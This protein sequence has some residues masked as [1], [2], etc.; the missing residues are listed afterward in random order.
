MG[1]AMTAARLIHLTVHGTGVSSGCANKQA[2]TDL[3]THLLVRLLRL[4]KG[5]LV[6]AVLRC[7]S[8]QLVIGFRSLS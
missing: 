7:C 2:D 1:I 6:V 4:R 5:F 8:E 3:G